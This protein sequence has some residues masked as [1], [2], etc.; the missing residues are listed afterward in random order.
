MSTRAMRGTAAENAA[1][2]M[3][4]VVRT[5]RDKMIPEKLIWI[6]FADGEVSAGRAVPA[7]REPEAP[8]PARRRRPLSAVQRAA[9]A[10]QPGTGRDRVG[11]RRRGRVGLAGEAC[12]P[13]AAPALA[14]ERPSPALRRAEPPRAV[15]R[16]GRTTGRLALHRPRGV[17]PLGGR[18]G[19][20]LRDD[21]PANPG[22]EGA[23]R[24]SL[25]R[26]RRRRTSSQSARTRTGT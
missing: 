9:P 26:A 1:V 18:R 25:R 17:R 2:K 3:G 10:L 23:A 13:H 5:V 8:Q 11:A 19:P 21:R 12:A 22:G 4:K 14:P 20:R 24:A 6:Q 16:L 15:H 7:V